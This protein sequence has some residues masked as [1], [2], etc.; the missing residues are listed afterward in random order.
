M[1]EGDDV[2][3]NL[4]PGSIDGVNVDGFGWFAPTRFEEISQRFD[5]GDG[6]DQLRM[7]MEHLEVDRVGRVARVDDER[8]R[9]RRRSRCARSH[10]DKIVERE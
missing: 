3:L 7:L 5:A 10:A 2:A 6:G 1:I 9:K 4:L 8:I